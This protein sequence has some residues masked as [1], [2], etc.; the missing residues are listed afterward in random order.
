MATGSA[1]EEVNDDE[2][3]DAA[4]ADGVAAAHGSEGDGG[5]VER[6]D[7][8]GVSGGETGIALLSFPDRRKRRIKRFR[9]PACSRETN[10]RF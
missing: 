10:A 7:E 8:S 4:A 9:K 1:A 6:P 5:A 2:E 3:D